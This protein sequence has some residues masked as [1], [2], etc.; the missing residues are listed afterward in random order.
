MKVST[1]YSGDYVEATYK[2]SKGLE[3]TFDKILSLPPEKS[4][5]TG[6]FNAV[7]KFADNWFKPNKVPSL[8]DV[9]SGLGVFPQSVRN[10]GWHCTALDP[11]VRSIK[12]L[13]ERIGVDT[14]HGDFMNLEP[15]KVF[16][17]VTLN[18]VL[19]HVIDPIAM[20]TLVN[21]WLAKDGF[22]YLELPDG[23]VASKYGPDREEFTIDHLNVFSIASTAILASRSGF[24]VKTICRL[25][26]PSSKYTI[27]A[28]LIRQD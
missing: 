19:E 18:K 28:I 24:T 6:R 15:S 21:K 20:L 22:V 10:G 5:N 17:V 4:D 27:R 25:Q 2:D 8:L 23:E 13:K 26:E 3:A 7:K 12:H 1:D 16:D 14:I 11:D 9:G